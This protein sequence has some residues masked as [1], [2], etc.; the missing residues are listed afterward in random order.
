MLRVTNGHPAMS[1][2]RPLYPCQ[3]RTFARRGRIKISLSQA[4]SGLL[5]P[6]LAHAFEKLGHWA[7][8]IRD[9][10]LNP[11]NRDVGLKLL[12]P[13]QRIARLIKLLRLRQAGATDSMT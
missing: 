8:L 3:N 4:V 5:Q 9:V 10:L 1:A 7:R 2:P 11:R 6:R 12:A 13:D